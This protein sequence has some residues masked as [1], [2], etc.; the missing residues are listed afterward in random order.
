[1]IDVGQGDA[2]ALRTPKWRWILVDAG[3]AWRDTD[4]GERI[5][6][7][8]LRRRGGSLAAMIVSHP[9]ADHIG[10]A[11]SVL[12]RVPTAL[13]LDGGY[14]Q[15][16]SVYEGL[17]A[18]ARDEGVAWRAARTGTAITIDGVALTVLAPDS[19]EIAN[20]ADANAASVV[21]MAEYRGA[22]VLLTGDAEKNVEERLVGRFGPA[23][24][25][26]ILKVGHH[27]SST[28]STSGLLAVVKPRLAL[29]SV[30]AGNRYGHPSP[31]V[32]GAL[33]SSGAH[34]LRTDEDGSIVVTLDGSDELQVETSE[35]R[36][37]LRRQPRRDPPSRSR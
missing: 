3:D 34:V 19:S 23:L 7:P 35:S 8:Y 37:R 30:G 25:A 2:I 15:G 18:R 24:R 28:S 33:Q 11:A 32:L 21:V 5:V 13:L 1:M 27:G 20:A 14:A 16:S 17:L 10:G 26:D 9:H 12:S 22:K 6:A 31:D 4:V 36:W 29:I